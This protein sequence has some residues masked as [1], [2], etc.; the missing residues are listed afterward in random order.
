M[1]R[2]HRHRSRRW[3]DVRLCGFP[4]RA[5]VAQAMAWVDA[6]AALGAETVAA[7]ETCGRI[8]HAPLAAGADLPAYDRAADDGYAVRSSETIGA[9]PYNPIPLT[10]Q[11]ADT[12]LA[13]SSAALVNAGAPLPHGADAVLPFGAANR[14]GAPASIAQ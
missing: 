14:A 1:A 6:H 13:M 9:G 8:L 2:E 7:G 11:A 5:S 10:V 3:V 12:P 4:E